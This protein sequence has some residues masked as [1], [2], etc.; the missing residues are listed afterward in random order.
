MNLGSIEKSLKKLQIAKNKCGHQSAQINGHLLRFLH[1][2]TGRKIN[3]I[4]RVREDQF[5]RA[6]SVP[7]AF[8]LQKRT[9]KLYLRTVCVN[10]P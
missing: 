2:N 5:T 8:L 3:L 10:K 6:F 1:F 9:S 4:K 7:S